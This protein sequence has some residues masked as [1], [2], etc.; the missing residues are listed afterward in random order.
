MKIKNRNSSKGFTLIELLVVVLI[1]GILA[2]IAL[3]QYQ[4]SVNRSR[5]A[6]DLIIQDTLVKT[7]QAARLTGVITYNTTCGGSASGFSV[8]TT[9][10][11]ITGGMYGA[12]AESSAGAWQELLRNTLGSMHFQSMAKNGAGTSMKIASLTIDID[13]CGRKSHR[14]FSHNGY[15]LFLD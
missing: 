6:Q 10:G 15:V 7:L 5:R 1:I 3:P 4:K 9:G 2:A 12:A 11:V 14:W 8:S 13:P